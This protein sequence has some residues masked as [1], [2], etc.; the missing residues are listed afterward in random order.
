MAEIPAIP[1]LID[2]LGRERMA[3]LRERIAT[4]EVQELRGVQ[5]YY[6]V[7][8]LT[9][10]E[11]AEYVRAIQENEMLK[12][13]IAKYDKRNLE[14][15]TLPSF[16]E[17]W[18]ANPEF[19]N[20]IL[21]DD[22]PQE[23]KWKLDK[24]FNYKLATNFMPMYARRLYTYFRATRVLDG[25]AG[26]GDRMAG[27]LSAGGGG[28]VRRYVGFDPNAHLVPGYEKIQND[29]GFN[30]T[31]RTPKSI[32]F[33]S[34]FK[35]HTALF[36]NAEE[37]LGDERFDFAFTGPPFFDYEDYGEHMPKYSNW[38]EQFYIPL[39]KITH[40]HLDGDAFFAVY[41]NDTIS[42]HIEDFMMRE[43]PL[44]TSFKFKGKV[45]IVGGSSGKIRDIFVFRRGPRNP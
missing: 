32:E 17:V 9:S 44:I 33:S 2:S 31:T 10:I 27:A 18:I 16:A 4:D 11:P 14:M 41:L 23:A 45:G 36:E 29:F 8:R 34:K 6:V 24:H 15:V 21:N 37:L 28:T 1:M 22:D 30:V 25:C 38:I 5:G 35:I 43:V 40:D 20:A 7:F 39:F 42:G 19:R 12:T 26:W 3:E 13:K